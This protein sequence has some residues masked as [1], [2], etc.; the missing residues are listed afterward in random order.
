M[1][2]TMNKVVTKICRLAL[3]ITDKE[4]G[5]LRGTFERQET[6]LDPLKTGTQIKYNKLGK[7]N[8][9]ILD[10]VIELKTLIEA[11]KELI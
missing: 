11:G 8:N 2:S 4:I 10:K 6:F 7:H 9:L 5:V 1:N 3:T